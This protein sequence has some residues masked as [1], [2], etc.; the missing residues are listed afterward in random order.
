MHND[1]TKKTFCL[2]CNYRLNNHSRT[3]TNS[4]LWTP[5]PLQ[6]LK[7][8]QESTSSLTS[9]VC[10]PEPCHY[11]VQFKIT[12]HSIVH[13]LVSR[14]LRH[15][16]LP[17]CIHQIFGVEECKT[18]E[19]IALVHFLAQS[20]IWHICYKDAVAEEKVRATQNNY[21]HW[22]FLRN[23]APKRL[24]LRDKSA[25]RAMWFV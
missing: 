12:H 22:N 4:C 3:A 16:Q 21:Y 13:S 11:D 1:I 23:C 10:A 17:L 2:S 5:H 25:G 8:A 9:T 24:R 6:S 15:R 19:G 14:R 7:S 18:T 20:S